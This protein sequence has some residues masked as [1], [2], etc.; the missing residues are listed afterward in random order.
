[1]YLTKSGLN[2]ASSPTLEET[3]VFEVNVVFDELPN[4]SLLITFSLKVNSLLSIS[5]RAFRSRSFKFLI[6]FPFYNKRRFLL[7]KNIYIFF[8][9]RFFQTNI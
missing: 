5:S 1:M 9:Y 7:T 2:I 4:P 3:S 8:T 6:K